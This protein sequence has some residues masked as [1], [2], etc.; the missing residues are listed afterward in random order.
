MSTE[1]IRPTHRERAG[2]VYIRQSTLQQVRHHQESQRRQYELQQLARELGFAQVIVIDD[3]LGVSGSG[4]KERP[5]FGRLLTAV[6]EGRVGAV[7]ALEASRL[8]RNNR[9]WHHLIDLCLLTDTLV[10]DGDGVY[11]P[12]QLNDR[13]VLGLKGTMSEFEL[14]LLRQ[15]AQEA[16]RQKI[17]RGEVLTEVPVGYVRTE[18]NGIEMTPDRQV[19]E[20]IR[21]VFLQFR[22]L[23]SVR[24][25]LLWYRQEQIPVCGY[26]RNAHGKQEVLWRLPV[27]SRLLAILKNPVYAGAFAYGRTT[28]RSRMIEGRARKTAGHAVAM[29]Q[30]AVLIRDHHPGYIPWEE[31]M[32]NQKQI[33]DNLHTHHAQGVGAAKCGPALLAGL[34]RCARCGRK[35]HVAYSGTEG[36]V[37]RYHCRGGNINHGVE[38]C[39]SFG[40]LRADQTVVGTLLE[41]VQ[42]S[43]IEAALRAWERFCSDQNHQRRTVELAVEKARYEADRTRR[44]YDCVDP[45]NRLVAGELEVRWNSALSQL[46]EAEAKLQ[47]LESTRPELSEIQRQRLWQLGADLQAAW[48][49]PA[50]PVQLKK[51]I[52]RTVIEEIVVDVDEGKQELVFRIHWKGGI[53]TSLRVHKNRTG[54]HQRTTD[55]EVVDLVRELVQVSPDSSIASI[56]NRLGYETGAGNTW[57]ESRVRYLRTYHQIPAFDETVPRAWITLAEAAA[58]LK[59]HPSRVRKLIQSGILPAHQV[60]RH[61]PWII[62][63]ED[64]KRAEIS[65]CLSGGPGKRKVPRHQNDQ[66]VMSLL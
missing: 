8:A 18:A 22:R 19:Q 32:Q 64:L 27:Y 57:T 11:D 21:G 3:D 66:N 52:L 30:W 14:G 50:A 51:R 55:R 37:P 16:L 7:L 1:K 24:Q 48:D 36:R 43:G 34:L 49:N 10:I 61:A 12:R 29:E 6:C 56:L 33:A 63:A 46:A 25:M 15:R 4:S 17:Q 35:L 62:K 65:R 38:F 59:I 40:G 26:E 9:D 41:A 54:A 23:G 44:Q 2:Y 42:P 58:E 53:H 39:L 31:Y 5:G 20:A 28:T 45:E 47:S 60:V 13:L